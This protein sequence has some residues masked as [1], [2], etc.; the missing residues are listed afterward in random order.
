MTQKPKENME[1]D[2]ITDTTDSKGPK[3]GHQ[4]SRCF[5]KGDKLF[6]MMPKIVTVNKVL[7]AIIL[8]RH[9]LMISGSLF[10]ESFYNAPAKFQCMQ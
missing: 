3:S 2:I 4:D 10:L 1:K 6:N 5:K 8:L 9:L 7:M